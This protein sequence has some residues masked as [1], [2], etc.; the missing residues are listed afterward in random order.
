MLADVPSGKLVG[1]IEQTSPVDG[2]TEVERFTVPVNPYKLLTFT[3]TPPLE[4]AKIV[5][6]FGTADR[7][8]S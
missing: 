8:K 4:P 3:V 1:E 2:D 5:I 7:L 6:A